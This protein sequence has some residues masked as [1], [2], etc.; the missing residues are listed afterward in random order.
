MATDQPVLV[1]AYFESLCP[2][3][4][5]FITTQLYPTWQKLEKTGIM[6]VRIIPF[7]KAIVSLYMLF[8]VHNLNINI[9]IYINSY[10]HFWF[11][12]L[13]K[14]LKYL[15]SQSMFCCAFV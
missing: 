6:S 9:Y 14:V 4:I 8:L 2:D 5:R 3:S 10:V 12:F 11:T 7:G 1:E 13:T 15:G